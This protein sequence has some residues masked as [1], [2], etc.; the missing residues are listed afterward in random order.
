MIAKSGNTRIKLTRSIGKYPALDRA[1]AM[2]FQ[3]MWLS[4]PRKRN[5][6]GRVNDE[7]LGFD[8][9]AINAKTPIPTN[10]DQSGCING[11]ISILT[12]VASNLASI[13]T[14]ATIKPY[15]YKMLSAIP[16]PNPEA[17][18]KAAP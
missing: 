1:V 6:N 14:F 10:A 8:F 17:A 5:I 13:E 18:P 9:L 15:M 2:L 16:N 12:A 11:V 7:P 4:I 3:M